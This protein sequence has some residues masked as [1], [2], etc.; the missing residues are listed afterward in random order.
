M[1]NLSCLESRPPIRN[2]HCLHPYEAPPCICSFSQ[3]CT[4]QCSMC[5]LQVGAG[6]DG[7]LPAWASDGCG[8]VVT[9]EPKR[10]RNMGSY[11]PAVPSLAFCVVPVLQDP[12]PC[13]SRLFLKCLH[14]CFP[15][16]LHA[17]VPARSAFPLDM[18]AQSLEAETLSPCRSLL[19]LPL[20]SK[21]QPRCAKTGG[22]E[23]AAKVP[24]PQK[25]KKES[26][27]DPV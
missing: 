3:A 18:A 19:S 14:A 23:A 7:K 13:M 16:S 26:L 4:R 21:F 11:M 1:Q 17:C 5:A 12:R 25:Q 2:F 8:G 10:R 27:Q 15:A 24:T 20:K 6:T 22:A 9:K